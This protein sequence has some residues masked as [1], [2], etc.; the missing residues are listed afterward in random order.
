MAQWPGRCREEER[1]RSGMSSKTRHHEHKHSTKDKNENDHPTMTHSEELQRQNAA[2]Q[3][4]ASV[5]RSPIEIVSAAGSS[6]LS[7]A[8]EE[9]DK[10][11]DLLRRTQA[12]FENYQ[13]R[14][15]REAENERKYCQRP[16]ALEI[17][18]A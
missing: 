8:Q 11:L 14:A 17:I 7:K 16:L 1:R 9:R 2:D 10:Y 6:D 15:A 12:E 18:P 13:K 3:T 5:G 4:T